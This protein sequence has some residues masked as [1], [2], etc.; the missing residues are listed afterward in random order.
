MAGFNIGGLD[1]Y[2][3]GGEVKLT[4]S[5]WQRTHKSMWRKGTTMY[6]MADQYKRQ[7]DA[8]LA[9]MNSSSHSYVSES[10]IKYYHEKGSDAI[11]DEAVS[12]EALEMKKRV[13]S[14]GGLEPVGGYTDAMGFSGL[15][16]EESGWGFSA[17]WPLFEE[18]IDMLTTRA[19][20]IK[21]NVTEAINKIQYAPATIISG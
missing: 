18:C 13:D 9:G 20:E 7:S 21:E 6:K 11:K 3:S 4:A 10:G 15:E 17:N 16:D 19:K 14:M 12:G 5:S 2:K 8:V 1:Y